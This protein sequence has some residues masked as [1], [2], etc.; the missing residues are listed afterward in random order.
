MKRRAFVSTVALL[1]HSAGL[2]RAASGDYPPLL[3]ALVGYERQ[4][5]VR[6]FVQ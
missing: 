2:L 4:A 6:S 5:V 1:P 3:L